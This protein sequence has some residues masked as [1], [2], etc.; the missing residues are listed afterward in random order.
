MFLAVYYRFS[1]PALHSIPITNTETN[2]QPTPMSSMT[3]IMQTSIPGPC[4]SRRLQQQTVSATGST[5]RL[6]KIAVGLRYKSFECV[7]RQ[8]NIQFNPVD[9]LHFT[10][11]NPIHGD[12]SPYPISTRTG[13]HS[14]VTTDPFHYSCTRIIINIR[15][16]I[17]HCNEPH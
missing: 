8:T 17:I 16:F 7:C 4:R 10:W 11:H 13:A 12:D 3:M 1:H 6:D 9:C 15:Y 5:E 2:R 14:P